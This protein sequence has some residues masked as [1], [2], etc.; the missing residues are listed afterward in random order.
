MSTNTSTPKIL[1]VEVIQTGARRRWTIE[2]KLRIVAES[3]SARRM[4][5][6]TAR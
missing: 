2:E 5:K 1:P 4:V 6:P 3:F